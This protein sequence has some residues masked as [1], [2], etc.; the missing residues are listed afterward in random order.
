MR[1]PGGAA[2]AISGQAWNSVPESPHG[3][4]WRCYVPGTGMLRVVRQDDGYR[5]WLQTGPDRALPGRGGF[6]DPGSAMQDAARVA[7]GL[8]PRMFAGLAR[9]E[10]L[11]LYRQLARAYPQHRDGS[12]AGDRWYRELEEARSEVF[13]QMEITALDPYYI[14]PQPAAFAEAARLASFGAVSRAEMASPQRPSWL[15]TRPGRLTPGQAPR[16]RQ[17]S[18][19]ARAR[20]GRPR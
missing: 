15:R 12:G 18:P 5:W 6:V 13:R 11:A 10:L 9:D 17:V 3:P 20:A 19:A 14:G 16:R 4:G 2:A 8:A 7:G 1:D